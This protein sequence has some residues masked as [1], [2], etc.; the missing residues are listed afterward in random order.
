MNATSLLPH[1]PSNLR[2]NDAV[3]PVGTPN[4]PYFG[5]HLDHPAPDQ[6]QAGYQLL[7]AASAAALQADLSDM[8]DSGF[9]PGRCQSHVTYGG[10]P[11]ASSTHYFWKV[12]VWDKLG[13]VSSYSEPASFVTGLLS[14]EA[15]AG[16]QWIR[17]E[18]SEPDDYTYY[19]QTVD[20]MDQPIRRATLFI[21][22]VHKYV[23]YLNGQFVGPG[24][25][26]HYPQY[27]YYNA[28]NITTYLR[29]KQKNIFA[30]LTHWFGAGQGRPESARGLIL[31]AVIEHADGARTLVGTNGDWKQRRAEGWLPG[32]PARNDEGV[33]YVEVIDAA[34]LTPD[35]NAPDYDDSAWDFA[36]E[37]GPHPTSPWLGTLAPDLTR[38][39]ERPLES[40]S[41][42]DKGSGTY[43]IDLGRVCAGRPQIRFSGG[44]PG[45][46]VEMLSGYTL[47]G[48][49]MV[50]RR[51]S[52]N[53]DLSYGALLSGGQFTFLPL[54]YLGMRY[55][56][57]EHSPLPITTENFLF[58]ERHLDLDDDRSSFA[59]SDPILNRVWDFLKNS[60]KPCA[61]EA[62]IDT[63]TREKGGFLVD[64]LNES[65]VAM[66]AYGE[67]LSTRKALVEFLQSMDHYWSSPADQGRMNAVYPN[68]DGAR[69]IPDFTQAYLW[70]AWQYYL[71]TGDLDFLR[72]YYPRLRSIAEYVHQHQQPESG[73]IHR[74]TGGSGPYQYGIVD[75]PPSMRYGYDMATEARTVIN[76]YAY[77]DYVCVS[78]IAAQLGELADRD[79][80]QALA[81]EIKT[82][83][84]AK[85][86]NP[87][88]LYVDGL[89]ADGRQSGHISQHANMFPLA[90]GLVPPERQAAL[91]AA[92][93]ERRMSVG[94]A[95]VYWLI[96]ALG[97]ADQGEH[98]LDLYTNAEW[99]GWA[100]CL[101]QG[102]T[103]TWESWDAGEG[104]GLSQ[105]H[106]WGAIG[107]CGLQQYV[108]GVKPLLPQFEKIQ[109]KPLD[110][111]SKLASAGGRLPTERGEVHVGW[112]RGAD[113]F[114]LTLDLPVN[115]Q[116][117]VCLP[118][119]DRWDT[120][121][122][123]D[124][125]E[126][127]GVVE[128]NYVA[129]DNIGSGTHTFERACA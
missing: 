24:P 77:L 50:D 32:T 36:V 93:K 117:H 61:Q 112:Q 100:R 113:R 56:Q 65:L 4:G 10:R 1:A 121:M 82:T 102:A 116:A 92:V 59:S 97:E 99:D 25:S 13:N 83:I 19:R 87:D 47:D 60:L 42:V 72:Q 53:T 108:L 2:V 33:G 128:G 45:A 17:R 69:D 96:R 21:S 39:V 12:R 76:A 79:A 6:I 48:D 105:S 127:T 49:G 11:L 84:N 20:L 119:L 8:W 44:T 110:F 109:V 64:S 41:I 78:K 126:M 31:K 125:V 95:T 28:Y 43:V 35:W 85:L 62:F 34:R 115:V 27:Q 37:I 46:R 118:K 3:N 80:Y 9:V 55:F 38:I 98:L 123:V 114:R 52:Q 5:W 94:M 67:R 7:V 68:G 18:I 111:G 30:V 88:G 58:L 22:A 81:E 63:P 57:V 29:P 14:D 91:L 70:W 15:W 104:G 26:Y 51:T 120:T 23:L 122:C 16:A 66:S 106:G 124:G 71:Q 54:E 101:A 129:V 40:V 107:L 86:V 103:C 75:W 90:L 73:L 74:L 89:Y